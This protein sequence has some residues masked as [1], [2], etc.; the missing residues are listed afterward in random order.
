MSGAQK[1]KRLRTLKKIL[2]ERGDDK[3]LICISTQLI[4]AGV[5]IDFNCVIRYVA[6]LDS[7][8]QA[9]GR[10]NRNG[11]MPEKG[12]L[13]IINHKY[14]NLSNLKDIRR[15][16]SAAISVLE[17][18]KTNT[19]KFN[20]DL[21]GEYAINRYFSLIYNELGNLNKEHFEYVPADCDDT[22]YDLLSVN[23]KHAKRYVRENP[24]G[25]NLSF[26]QAFQTA[27]NLF[28]CIDAETKGIIVPHGKGK[29]LIA[30]LASAENQFYISELLKYA[31][32]YSIN[33]F[34][35]H[36]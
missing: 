13:Y 3:R 17:E 30:E 15:G 7:I 10:C 4:E 12:N 18:Y 5:D 20:N 34:P 19:E 14:E 21:L 16:Q 27:G 25:L 23:A 1:K 2:D 24:G 32:P 22:L 6:G 28:K 35:L 36:V 29:E 9:A 33:I 31:Q 8:A 26:L 11:R